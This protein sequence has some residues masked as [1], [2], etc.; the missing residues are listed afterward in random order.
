[1]ANTQVVRDYIAT[2]IVLGRLVGPLKEVLL[3]LVKTS[4][5]GLVPKSHN[6]DKWRMIVDLSFPRGGSVNSSISSELSSITYAKIDDAV[7]LILQLGPGTQLA[8]LD[9][10]SAYRKDLSNPMQNPAARPVAM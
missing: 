2:E 9:L 3:P 10:K 4:P 7:E 1:M 5:I 6:V 8:K